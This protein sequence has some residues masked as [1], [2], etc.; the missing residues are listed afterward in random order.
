MAWLSLAIVLFLALIARRQCDDGIL[1][2][3][4]FSL[5]GALAVGLGGNILL[6]TLTGSPRWSLV[7]GVLG[8]VVGG[9]V[10][11]LITGES[12]SSGGEE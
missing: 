11:G 8:V 1:A 3:T 2:G 12:G 5:I 6:T 10:I 4:G 9:Y 7:V